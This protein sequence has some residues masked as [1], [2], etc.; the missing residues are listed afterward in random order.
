M[1]RAGTVGTHPLFV[2]MIRELIEERLSGTTRAPRPWGVSR[3]AGC[4]PGGLLP[5]R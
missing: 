1:V 3:L 4:V 2:Q 5:G